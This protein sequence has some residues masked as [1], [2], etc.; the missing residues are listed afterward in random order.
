MRLL[1]Y[2]CAFLQR[3]LYGSGASVL[4]GNRCRLVDGIPTRYISYGGPIVDD[5]GLY[6]GSGEISISQIAFTRLSGPKQ[7]D[8]GDATI[9]NPQYAGVKVWD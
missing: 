6:L 3:F 1:A 9:N 2:V 7:C 8:Y 5:S 4:R